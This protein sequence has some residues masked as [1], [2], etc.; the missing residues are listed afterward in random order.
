[1]QINF[2]RGPR[3][4][5][6]PSFFMDGLFKVTKVHIKGRFVQGNRRFPVI[7]H[8]PLPNKMKNQVHLNSSVS[9]SHLPIEH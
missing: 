8:V 9:Q 3:S 5:A 4:P 7:I 2:M 6:R 1:M